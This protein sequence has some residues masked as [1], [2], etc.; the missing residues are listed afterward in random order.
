MQESGEGLFKHRIV[1]GVFLNRGKYDKFE[2]MKVLKT[3]N[4][5]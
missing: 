4:I 1:W 3:H 2:Q 5:R